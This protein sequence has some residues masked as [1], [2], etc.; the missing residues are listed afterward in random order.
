MYLL[1]YNIFVLIQFAGITGEKRKTAIYSPT[2]CDAFAT[3]GWG[4]VAAGQHHT[5]AVDAAGVAHAL[6]RC[7]Y[8]RCVRHPPGGRGDIHYYIN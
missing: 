6:G 7:E 8:G 3:R 2:W 1:I 4:A 5:L